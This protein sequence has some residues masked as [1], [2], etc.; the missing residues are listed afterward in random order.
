M[1][2]SRIEAWRGVSLTA[3]AGG[4]GG[5]A[6]WA[7][8]FLS[9]LSLTAWAASGA[10]SSSSSMPLHSSSSSSFPSADSAAAA[11]EARFSFL[12]L[13]FCFFSALVLGLL[14]GSLP[15]SASFFCRLL[16]FLGCPLCS[17]TLSHRSAKLSAVTS[18][19]FPGLLRFLAGFGAEAGA[20]IGVGPPASTFSFSAEILRPLTGNIVTET[21]PGLQK[22]RSCTVLPVQ[23]RAV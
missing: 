7:L 6:F 3:G 1:S 14:C 4:A 19:E 17:I 11:S 22:R 16:S 8:G 23:C 21:N 12:S 15:P 20:A 5:G 2:F 13:F 10:L 18:P 9:A